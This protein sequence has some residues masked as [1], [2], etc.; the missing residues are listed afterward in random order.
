MV[1]R[2]TPKI[3]TANTTRLNGSRGRKD[4]RANMM[5][6]VETVAQR[7]VTQ[8][9][10]SQKPPERRVRGLNDSSNSRQQAIPSQFRLRF[11][12]PSPHLML[13]NAACASRLLVNRLT[14]WSRAHAN[15]SVRVPLPRPVKPLQN[16]FLR[17]LR[18][19]MQGSKVPRDSPSTLFAVTVNRRHWPMRTRLCEACGKNLGL[20]FRGCVRG[21]FVVRRRTNQ[22]RGT[23]GVPKQHN[24]NAGSAISQGTG[25]DLHRS[26]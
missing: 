11:V 15:H 25:C 5:A 13:D 26:P 12:M 4:E 3:P 9:K 22:R 17:S 6:A 10:R 8:E 24:H 23:K 1:T 18:A 19:V 14:Q 16:R 21:S 7:Q 2:N 20:R